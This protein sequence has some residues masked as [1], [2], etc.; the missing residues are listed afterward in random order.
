ML[1]GTET[2]FSNFW[3]GQDFPNLMLLV[4]FSPRNWTYFARIRNLHLKSPILYYRGGL[5]CVHFFVKLISLIDEVLYFES[6]DLKEWSVQC[7]A[8]LYSPVFTNTFYLS[9]VTT[10][11]LN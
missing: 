4:S 8:P 10:A 3:G 1:N 6:L 11:I 7:T 5:I 9:P 2:H